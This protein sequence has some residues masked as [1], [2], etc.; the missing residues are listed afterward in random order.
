M[1]LKLSPALAL[2]LTL[3]GAAIAAAEHHSA[4]AAQA[5]VAAAESSLPLTDGEVQKADKDAGKLTIKHGPITN[6]GMPTMTMVFLVKDPAIL[7]KV[8]KGDKIRFAADKASGALTVMRLEPAG[9]AGGD[10][11]AK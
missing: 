11:Q 7:D 5:S 10:T 3:S 9:E 8:K 1:L 4:S 2:L 6:L